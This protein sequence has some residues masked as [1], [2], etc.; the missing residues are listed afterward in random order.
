MKIIFEVLESPDADE[1]GKVLPIE[2]AEHSSVTVG[3]EYDSR[4]PLRG[5]DYISRHH[6]V[7]EVN[8]PRCYIRDL[9]SKNGTFVRRR[10]A[11]EEAWEQ[12]LPH[13]ATEL[14]SGDV[15]R[16]GRMPATR[17]VL[18]VRFE[19]PL[20]ETRLEA[21]VSPVVYCVQCASPAPGDITTGAGDYICPQC[22][23]QAVQHPGEARLPTLTPDYELL[24]VI[25]RGAMGVVYKARRITPDNPD[26]PP[27]ALVAIKTIIPEKELQDR[28]RARFR[29]EAEVCAALYHPHL[30]RFYESCSFDK[31]ETLWFAME[32]VD[33]QNAARRAPLALDE[34]LRITDQLLDALA[35][36]HRAPVPGIRNGEVVIQKGAAHRDIKPGNILISGSGATLH[37]KLTDFGLAKAFQ[38][39]GQSNFTGSNACGGSP[40]YM[41]PEHIKDF[42]QAGPLA[43]IYAMGATLYTL[44][45]GAL[46]YAAPAGEDI[47]LVMLE[48]PIIPPGEPFPYP[49]LRPLIEQATQ[50]RPEDRFPSAAAM[51]AALAEIRRGV[52]GRR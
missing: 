44:L 3:R 25:G 52:D 8:E 6:L 2:L 42:Q 41:S 12:S 50:K 45:T 22:R 48:E 32:Y 49:A 19:F 28:D 38:F 7:V 30:V 27:S 33:G 18:R 17:T 39:A 31:A 15:I 34:A 26:V 24:S 51:R 5:G 21:D 23:A 9:G 36:A 37:A 11:S 14:H 20:P 4:L 16:L 10:A 43:D 29:R 40:H 1:R 47:F 35:Y 13:Q 46:P